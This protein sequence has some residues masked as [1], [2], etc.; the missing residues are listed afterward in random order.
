[1]TSNRDNHHFVQLICG[2][3]APNASEARSAVEGFLLR[4]GET[5]EIDGTSTNRILVLNI[6]CIA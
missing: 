4:E 2:I 3:M 6:V 5:F 1:M